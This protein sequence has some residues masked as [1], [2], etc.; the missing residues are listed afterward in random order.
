MGRRFTTTCLSLILWTL[1]QEPLAALSSTDEIHKPSQPW[2]TQLFGENDIPC[3]PVSQQKSFSIDNLSSLD[4]TYLMMAA[5]YVA[6]SFWPGKRQRIL[7]SWGFNNIHIFDALKSSPNGFW[8]EHKD[9]VLIAFRGT[10]EPMDLFTDID[11]TLEPAFEESGKNI[12]VHSGFRSAAKSVWSHVQ[13][14]SIYAK[15]RQK[16]LLITGHSLGGAIALLSAIE[17]DINK[18]QSGALWTFGAPNVGNNIFFQF[19]N[20]TLRHRWNRINE[21][22]D[23]IPAL[24]F[25]EEDRVV[26]RQWSEKFGYFLPLLTTFANNSNY[27]SAA[28]TSPPS[29]HLKQNSISKRSL[30]EIARGFL[31]HLPRSYVCRLSKTTLP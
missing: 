4:N 14:A 2:T 16:P 3:L 17:L 21:E 22:S 30:K 27:A 25:T 19:A 29:I 13:S 20:E 7:S 15:N 8:A 9:F 6:Y 1:A 31:N 24:P 10:Q 28:N 18:Q 26:V 5:S 23:P 12:L 11:V